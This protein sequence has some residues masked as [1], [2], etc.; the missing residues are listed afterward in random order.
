MLLF[1][2]IA[3]FYGIEDNIDVCLEK[4]G[5]PITK[6]YASISFFLL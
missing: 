4:S 3:K 1:S 6:T 5:I 2:S